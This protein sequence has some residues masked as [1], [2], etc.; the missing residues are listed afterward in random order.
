MPFRLEI[1]RVGK[2]PTSWSFSKL[3]DF[4]TVVPTRSSRCGDRLCLLLRRTPNVGSPGILERRKSLSLIFS[5]SLPFLL[6]FFF[7]SLSPFPLSI[8][9]IKLAQV[10]C[11][12]LP[13]VTSSLVLL[14]FSYPL[15]HIFGSS[16][17]QVVTHGHP[18]DYLSFPLHLTHG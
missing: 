5:S 16:P 17:S 12:P 18:L 6:F 13:R 3:P 7:F 2:F 8:G 9:L 1:I 14:D 4:G 11:P 10:G 15:I